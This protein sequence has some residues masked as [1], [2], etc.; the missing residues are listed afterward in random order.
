MYFSLYPSP[1]TFFKNLN[2]FYTPM[3]KKGIKENQNKPMQTSVFQNSL[4]IFELKIV[5]KVEE[6][7]PKFFCCVLVSQIKMSNNFCVR[8]REREGGVKF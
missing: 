2:R 8:R 7:R 4:F 5:C 3:Y 1:L 6:K